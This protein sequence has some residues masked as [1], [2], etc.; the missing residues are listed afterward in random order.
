MEMQRDSSI[1]KAKDAERRFHYITQIHNDIVSHLDAVPAA[2]TEELRQKV[3]EFALAESNQI[4]EQIQR[5]KDDEELMHFHMLR[6]Y[7]DDYERKTRIR[8]LFFLMASIALWSCWNTSQNR[9]KK[10]KAAKS[11]NRKQ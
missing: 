9:K 6:E 3:S 2:Y 8:S 1:E 7:V 10:P 5:E 4:Q 11:V